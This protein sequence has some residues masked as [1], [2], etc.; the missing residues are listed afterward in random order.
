M[1]VSYLSKKIVIVTLIKEKMIVIDN[2]ILENYG[3]II[4]II[5]KF[6]MGFLMFGSRMIWDIRVNNRTQ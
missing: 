3:V 6:H 5:Q 2:R 4:P 1:P